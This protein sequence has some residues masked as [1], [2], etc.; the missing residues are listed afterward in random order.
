MSDLSFVLNLGDIEKSAEE[1]KAVDSALNAAAAKLSVQAHLH[2]VEL[3]Q[4]GLHARREMY[5]KGLSAPKQVSTGTWVISL[6]PQ[7][8]WIDNGLPSH[9][10][11]PDLLR[12]SPYGNAKSGPKTS[13]DGSTYRVI[14][15]EHMKGPSRQTQAEKTLTDTIKSAFKEQNIPYKKAEYDKSGSPLSGLVRKFDKEAGDRM[16]PTRPSWARPEGGPGGNAVNQHGFGWGIPG[17]QKMQG[18]TGI[19]FL[20][21]LRV[22]QSPIFSQDGTP[23]FNKAGEA[24]VSKSAMTFRV[25]SSKQEDKWMYPGIVGKFF[26]EA[27]YSWMQNQWEREMLPEILK[28]L[29]VG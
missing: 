7:A 24:S 15:F 2:I 12:K 25:V 20:R 21:G 9:S 1:L 28:R 4:E 8:V 18:P 22:Y 29:G 3:A 13:S 11:I 10:M 27:T 6:G 19:P 14:P 23:K 26:F 16:T 17:V 5:L